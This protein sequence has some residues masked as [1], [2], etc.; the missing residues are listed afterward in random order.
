MSY[1]NVFGMPDNTAKI[2][3]L[4]ALLDVG[5]TDAV[6]DGQTVKIS[7]RQIRKRLRELE[8]EDDTV[9]ARRPLA[10]TVDLTSL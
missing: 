1:A 10:M 6:I 7:P 8:A 2:A 5:A 9:T 4:N 3:H